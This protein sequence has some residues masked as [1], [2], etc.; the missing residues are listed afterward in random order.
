MLWSLPGMLS[1]TGCSM[2]FTWA[3]LKMTGKLL[4]R[5]WIWLHAQRAG[6]IWSGGGGRKIFPFHTQLTI[7][8][9]LRLLFTRIQM[10]FT[11]TDPLVLIHVWKICKTCMPSETSIYLGNLEIAYSSPRPV[12]VTKRTPQGYAACSHTYGSYL[13]V[14][15]A[16]NFGETEVQLDL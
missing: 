3:W 16:A 14:T 9:E 6:F 11:F 12:K 10:I 7:S 8:A 15:D 13:L 2:L 1:V 5:K 4:V